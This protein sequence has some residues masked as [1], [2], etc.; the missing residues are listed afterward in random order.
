[1]YFRHAMAYIAA[2]GRN[3]MEALKKVPKGKVW[4]T[5]ARK[6]GYL[7]KS[8]LVD[9]GRAIGDTELP[10]DITDGVAFDTNENDPTTQPKD[11]YSASSLA[12]ML[13]E[14]QEKL[15]NK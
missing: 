5:P 13:R 2:A 1:M 3:D 14:H 9:L 4:I 15:Q 7:R 12:L 11:K 10:K 8:V 6:D